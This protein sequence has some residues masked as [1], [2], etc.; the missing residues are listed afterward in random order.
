MLRTRFG[1]IITNFL[2]LVARRTKLMAFTATFGQI[3]PIIPFIFTAPFYFAGKIS[4]G[5]M[6]QTA[7]AF[8]GSRRHSPSS[9]NITS[10]WRISNRSSIV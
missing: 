5:I 9:S 1:A 2:A 6:I 4:L 3:S 8:T 7:E 10:R